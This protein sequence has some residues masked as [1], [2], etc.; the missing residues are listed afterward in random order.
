MTISKQALELIGCRVEYYL[1]WCKDIGFPCY[2]E[3]TKKEFFKRINENRIVRDTE[4][5]LLINQDGDNTNNELNE[6]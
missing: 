4:S 6:E 5:G 3:N 2:K 1:Q